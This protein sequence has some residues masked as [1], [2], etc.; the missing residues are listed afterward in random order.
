RGTACA[1]IEEGAF[2]G[3][4]A[5]TAV[6]LPDGPV[7][8]DADAFD[9][10]EDGSRGTLTLSLLPD[11]RVTLTPEEPLRD[12]AYRKGIFLDEPAEQETP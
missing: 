3:C 6:F 10:Y 5:L 7:T 8:M 2:A 1:A 12:W 9:T 11:T 4:G